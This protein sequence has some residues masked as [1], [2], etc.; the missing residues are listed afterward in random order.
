MKCWKGTCK[1][2]TNE[3]VCKVDNKSCDMKRQPILGTGLTEYHC[4]QD[5]IEALRQLNSDVLFC[6]DAPGDFRLLP[7][8]SCQNICKYYDTCTEA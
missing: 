4:R 3:N 2:C 6:P 8:W 1:Y 7:F 5:Q